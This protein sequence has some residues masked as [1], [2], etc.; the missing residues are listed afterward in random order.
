MTAYETDADALAALTAPFR[1][2][3][4]LAQLEVDR[5]MIAF[6]EADN[7]R[8]RAL[9]KMAERKSDG[10]SGYDCPWCNEGHLEGCSAFT[11][12]GDVR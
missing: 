8:L 7:A 3:W 5:G 6:L 4:A 9:I 1:L 2:Q 12:D 11:P 10:V